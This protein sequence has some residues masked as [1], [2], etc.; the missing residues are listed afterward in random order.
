MTPVGPS[1]MLIRKMFKL[2]I[3]SASARSASDLCIANL[4]R[5]FFLFVYLSGAS[6][7]HA[8]LKYFDAIRDEIK[9]LEMVPCQ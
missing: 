6:L 2:Q 3:E 9:S 7:S 8:I 5:V 4:A 1:T